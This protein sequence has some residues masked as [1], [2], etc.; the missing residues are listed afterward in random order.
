MSLPHTFQLIAATMEGGNTAYGTSGG[1]GGGGSVQLEDFS[2]GGGFDI[3]DGMTYFVGA[4]GDFDTVTAVIALEFF[5]DG[6][7]VLRRL[8][9]LTGCG[10]GPSENANNN[11][12]WLLSGSAGD[13][14]ARFDVDVGILLES[15]FTS[16]DSANTTYN[17]G[18]NPPYYELCSEAA[19][20]ASVSKVIEGTLKILDGSDN[21]LA[22]KR[23]RLTA[24]ATNSD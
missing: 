9:G 17:L 3:N 14:S 18:A 5:S 24:D 22:S 10:G 4:G 19:F 15:N 23:I 2:P 1:G 12:T 16:G 8:E 6:Q 7:Y 20:G 13:Y 11:F 21:V